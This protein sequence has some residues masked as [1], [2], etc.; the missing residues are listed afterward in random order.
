M[1]HCGGKAAKRLWGDDKMMVRE[2]GASLDN[3]WFEK[4]SQGETD[5]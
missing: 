5:G 1:W 4:N 2:S 3:G